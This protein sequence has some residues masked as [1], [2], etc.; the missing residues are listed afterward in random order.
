[1]SGRADACVGL[2][3]LLT[4]SQSSLPES[5]AGLPSHGGPF[6][7]GQGGPHLPGHAG[8]LHRARAKEGVAQHLARQQ[9]RVE[10]H[11]VRL[12][13]AGKGGGRDWLG[14]GTAVNG[15]AAPAGQAL[16][17]LSDV[18]GLD[19][20]GSGKNTP[21][22]VG[23]LRHAQPPARAAPCH[24]QRPPPPAPS[25]HRMCQRRHQCRQSAILRP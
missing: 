24:A 3:S 13:A 23:L 5:Q 19:Q 1:M 8:V 20:S 6:N 7:C 11:N 10:W 12:E 15:L 21:P 18:V 4:A 16:M 17:R 22:I 9:A 2:P 14:Q 25:A